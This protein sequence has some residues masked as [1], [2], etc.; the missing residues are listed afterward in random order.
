MCEREVAESGDNEDEALGSLFDECFESH[1][2]L[3]TWRRLPRSAGSAPIFSRLDRIYSTLHPIALRTQSV[4][5]GV[6]G[7]LESR[8][9]PSDHRG[10]RVVF[11]PRRPSAVSHA[12][13]SVCGVDGYTDHLRE[14]LRGYPCPKDLTA[15]MSILRKAAHRSRKPFSGCR[16][17]TLHMCPTV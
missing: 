12:S 3:R 15:K 11:R 6:V 14:Q 17:T 9:S 5:V 4:S 1:A 13:A 10:V 7:T 2:E 16:P 8:S